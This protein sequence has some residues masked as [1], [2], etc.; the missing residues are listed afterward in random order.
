MRLSG[1]EPL[2]LPEINGFIHELCQIAEQVNVYTSYQYKSKFIK[3]LPWDGNVMSKVILTHTPMDFRRKKFS[4]MTRR[5]PFER[6]IENIRLAGSQRMRKEIKFVLNHENLEE[7]MD[8]F[9]KLVQPDDTFKI[10]GKVVNIHNEF[11]AK[12]F[13][14][15]R[16]NVIE[17]LSSSNDRLPPTSERKTNML[18]AHDVRDSCYYRIGPE[19]LR[20]AL[21][22]FKD[23]HVVLD[24]RFCPFF[25]GWFGHKYHVGQNS[26][27][28][29]E[30]AFMGGKYLE[31]C[32]DC[33]L[34]RYKSEPS[35]S[36]E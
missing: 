10:V 34:M 4:Y 13:E 19:E 6:Y 24:Y 21:S 20:F 30:K 1:G 33:R 16:N 3:D 22:S 28:D 32:H 27:H 15:T 29:I 12:S 2:L 17:N 14:D 31:A 25:P 23:D 35:E 11:G 26:P 9:N 18:Q 36:S 8:L 5:F 7:Q